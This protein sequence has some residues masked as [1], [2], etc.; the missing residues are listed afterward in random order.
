MKKYSFYISAIRSQR[1]MGMLG[2]IPSN[3]QQL[4]CILIGCIFYGMISLDDLTVYGSSSI[5]QN[6]ELLKKLHLHLIRTL[7][8]TASLFKS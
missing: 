2:V 6:I 3:I 8:P 4:S 5:I 1:T 7:F